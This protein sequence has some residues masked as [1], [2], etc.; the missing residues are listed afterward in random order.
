MDFVLRETNVN[1]ICPPDK[2][3]AEAYIIDA[4]LTTWNEEMI[5]AT[6]SK[7]F[8]EARGDVDKVPKKFLVDCHTDWYIFIQDKVK[9]YW[10]NNWV[11]LSPISCFRA[12]Q[13][14]NHHFPFHFTP[15]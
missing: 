4:N 1:M 5:G 11:F 12:R 15:S 3:L 7:K 14:Q 10:G 8:E 13:I 2:V 6:E 9:C